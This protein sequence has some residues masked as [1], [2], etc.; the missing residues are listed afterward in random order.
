MEGS[1][2]SAGA[3]TIRR[4]AGPRVE[5]RTGRATRSE[6]AFAVAVPSTPL[7]ARALSTVTWSDAYAVLLPTGRHERDPTEWAE[8]IF[9]EPPPWV[10]ILLGVREVVVRAVGI[11]PGGSHAFDILDRTPKE[12]LLGTDQGHLSFRTS[13]L[14]EPDRVVVS[15]VVEVHNRRGRGYFGL[16]RRIHPWVVRGMLARATRRLGVAA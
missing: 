2:V 9:R 4:A 11:E 7:L 16:V 13:V 8:A 5:E 1:L 6:T 15:T 3:D 10:R 12:V 14:V